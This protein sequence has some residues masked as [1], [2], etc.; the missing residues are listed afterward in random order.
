[1]RL[2]I[3]TNTLISALIKN[4]FTRTIL[5]YSDFEFYYPEISLKE[6]R[7]HKNL[8]LK[9]SGLENKNFDELFSRILKKVKMVPTSFFQENLKKSKNIMKKIDLDDAVFI[10]LALT[11]KSPIWSDDAHFDNQK[12]IKNFKSKEISKEHLRY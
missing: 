6:I 2:V 5:F 3:G 12:F 4:S 8:I 7:K 1:M 9:E 11:L 10:A